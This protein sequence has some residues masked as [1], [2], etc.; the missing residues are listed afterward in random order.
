LGRPGQDALRDK[1]DSMLNNQ[2][3]MLD[4]QGDL[5]NEV[6]N[7]RKALKSCLDLR[8]RLI[9]EDIAYMKNR[10]YSTSRSR[11]TWVSGSKNQRNKS[12]W[13]LDFCAPT[14][15]VWPAFLSLFRRFVLLSL[16]GTHGIARDTINLQKI[17]HPE[18]HQ[19]Y[20]ESGGSNESD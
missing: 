3:A 13:K 7:F 12:N 1:Q 20:Q 17:D 11:F 15:R 9:E 5:L 16:Q 8:L 14:G 4:K 2:D 18:V 19:P 6:K 10:D